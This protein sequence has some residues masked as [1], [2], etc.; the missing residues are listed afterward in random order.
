MERLFGMGSGYV[1]DFSNR[2]FSEFVL[3]STGRD[4]FD[5]KYNYASGSKAN[6]L[7]AFWNEESNALVAKLVRDILDYMLER[8]LSA[9]E[10]ILLRQC[11]QTVVRLAQ[12]GPV[13]E[14]EALTALSAEADFEALAKEIRSAIERNEPQTGLDRL[15]TFVVK[16]VRA[17]CERRG[18]AV[19][20][21]KALHSLFG[22]YVKRL[23]YDGQIESE[24]TERILRSGIS[25]LES[26]NHVRNNQSFAHDNPILNYDEALLIF[27]HVAALVRFLRSIEK[28]C[29]M[30]QGEHSS[31]SQGMDEEIPF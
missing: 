31:R 29:R 27:N 13:V 30:D 22:E 8:P 1:L 12:D 9:D 10:G 19:G 15:H 11:R 4:I 14:L 7:R 24:M 21:D 20:P 23:R 2:T 17:L 6:R 16:Y 3:D 25:T 5:S 26:F 28:K 18:I